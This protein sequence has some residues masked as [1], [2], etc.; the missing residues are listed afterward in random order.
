MSDVKMSDANMVEMTRYIEQMTIKKAF[1]GFDR[2]DVYNK[3]MDLQNMFRE[4]SEGCD[5]SLKEKEVKNLEREKELSLQ[6]ENLRQKLNEMESIQKANISAR[7]I[8]ERA[9]IDAELE[10]FK[11]RKLQRAEKENYER[12]RQHTEAAS[13]EVLD[14]LKQVTECITSLEDMLKTDLE[15]GLSDENG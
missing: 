7:L 2:V 3:M 6:I 10:T 9:K 12:W 13:E 4:Y 1:R 11:L 5:K 14:N 15:A 8:I